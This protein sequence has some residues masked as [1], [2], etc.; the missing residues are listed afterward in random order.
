MTHILA[1]HG[2]AVARESRDQLW[3]LRNDA[4]SALVERMRKATVVLRADPE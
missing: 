4:P 3:F 1:D 2:Y